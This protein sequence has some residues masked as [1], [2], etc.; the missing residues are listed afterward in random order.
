MRDG[1]RCPKQVSL[2]SDLMLPFRKFSKV[3]VFSASVN[4]KAF[5]DK[6]FLAKSH[7]CLLKLQV[8]FNDVFKTGL[9]SKNP[10]LRY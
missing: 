8:E 2:K 7:T 4:F 6:Y 5:F 1:P 9:G 3:C 10:E